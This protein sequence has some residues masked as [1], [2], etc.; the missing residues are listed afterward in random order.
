LLFFRNSL[1]EPLHPVAETFFGNGRACLDVE[2]AVADIG[3]FESLHNLIGIKCGLEILLVGKDEDGDVSEK[4]FL[5]EGLEFFGA[6]S[7]SHVIGGVNDVNETI[8]VLVVVLPVGTDLTLTTD[9]PNVQFKSILSLF[10]SGHQCVGDEQDN[11]KRV[12]NSTKDFTY[13]R[14]NV[15][16]LGGHN[17]SG[18]FVT[19]GLQ[20]SGL[21]RVIKS[22]DENT[23]LFLVFL[24][25]AKQLKKSHF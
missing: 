6:F 25:T 19:H 7:E 3:K 23:S 12:L 9:I 22:K 10:T 5:K 8:S 2:V 11:K 24:Q 17:V 4:L 16:T 14:F 1:N 13:E 20:D 21:S 18:I 15:E